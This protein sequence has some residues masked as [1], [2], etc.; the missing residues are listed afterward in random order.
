MTE[1][2]TVAQA[3][4][5]FLAVQ[6]VQRDGE[7]RRF[8][9]GCMGIFGHGNVA[10]L[11]QALAQYEDLLPYHPA[12]NEQAMVHIAAGYAR[13]RNRLGTWAC[14]TSVGPG[15][16]NMVTG[17]ALATINRLPVL[18]LPGDTFATRYP[19][20]VLQQ[21]EVPHDASVSVNDTLR[22]V[23]RFYERVERPEQLI[24]AALEAMR[25][26]TDPAETGA[27]TLAM[28]EDVQAEAFDVPAA[29]LE[30]RTWTVYRQPPAPEA[31]RSAARVIAG[32]KRPLIVAG[33][34]VI[35][36]EATHALRAF[37][38][39]TR[40]PVAET[41]AGRGA[42]ISAHPL[43]LGAIGATGTAAANRLAREA[44]V[45]IGIGTR[46][47]DFTT[48]S[49]SAFRDAGVRFV[50]VNV[51]GFDAAKLGGVAVVSDAREALSALAEA[52]GEYRAPEEWFALAGEQSAA[53]AGEVA[54]LVSTPGRELP[55][56]A[57]VIGAINDAAGQ[58]GVVVCAAGS[59]PGDLHKL[60][61][62]RDPD[63]KSYHVEYGY[64]CMGY[65]IP[66]GIGVKLAAPERQVFVLVGDGSYLMLPGEL[67]TAV[68]ERI[69]IVIV[70]VDNHG[71]AS[72]GALSRSVG[73]A[74]FGTHYRFAANGSL[75]LDDAAGTGPAH[76][77]QPPGSDVLP[78]DLAANAESLG[79]RV[80]RAQTVEELRAALAEAAGGTDAGGRA[81]GASG[82]AA[83]AS[84]PTV[85]CIETDRYTGVPGYDGWWDVPVAE[86][87]TQDT[88]RAARA[89]YERNS[90]AQRQFLD[91]SHE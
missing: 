47:S 7:R 3:L 91:V 37:V 9:A 79:A 6:E 81:A 21:L 26:L 76:P 31:V 57:Q 78:I 44:D 55:S 56:Q 45:V 48:A 25:V 67:V 85:I 84:G 50:N 62:A 36:S 40:I 12:R 75:P 64:S 43:S 46:W 54:R 39:A 60:W 35:Y 24:P 1:N 73:S 53:W 58:T 74:G 32:A 70:L 80:I 69:P 16:T 72:I 38:E 66:G 17:A 59:A 41:Q 88:V 28:P 71:Y 42:L 8:F 29:F 82:R 89:E 65:E 49:K 52:L 13:Q 87:S 51:A 68:A 83:G 5:R 34:G 10:G 22:P 18:L 63:G 2:L 20:P 14:T 90:S 19:H 86:T 27:V 23:S 30:P 11:G 15:A 61:R 4:V 33:G 77:A